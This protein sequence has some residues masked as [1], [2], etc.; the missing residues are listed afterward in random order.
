MRSRDRCKTKKHSSIS[1]GYKE[2]FLQEN[3]SRYLET[4]GHD[5][6]SS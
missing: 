5:H 4:G 2:T 1:A 3:C 6:F